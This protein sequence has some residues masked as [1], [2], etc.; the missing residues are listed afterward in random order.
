MQQKHRDQD[1]KKQIIEEQ[2]PNQVSIGKQIEEG[3]GDVVE[4]AQQEVA[5]A[6]RPWYQSLRW[7]RIL[8][9]VYAIL[10][11]L[12]ALLSWWVFYHPVLAID[13]TITH[14]FQENQAPWLRFIMLAVSFTGNVTALSLGLIVLAT[15]LF[16]I[17]DLRL[18]A[19]MVVALSATS[20]L[21]NGLIKIIV[22][23]PRPTSSLVEIIQNAS[24]NSFPS[25]HV[26]AYIAFWGLLFSFAIIIFKGNRW[27][28]T[29]LLVI[30]GLFV[31]LVGPSRIYLGDHWASD[32]L[33]AYLIGGVLLGIALWIYL[34]LKS[35]GVLAPRGNRARRFHEKYL[36]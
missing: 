7:G 36:K 29:A 5:S 28:R 23:R 35:K 33:G 16:W 12:F 21:L 32:V 11:A 20:A 2:T 9:V 8:L 26:M 31:V 18:E 22:A 3:A 1:Q 13:V 30:S 15:A 4:E 25:G 17:V 27:W 34:A 14:E 6:R 19:V 24:G 10:I